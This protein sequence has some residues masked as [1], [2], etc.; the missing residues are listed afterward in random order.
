VTEFSAVVSDLLSHGEDVVLPRVI[1][2]K[3]STPREVGDSMAI[4]RNGEIAGTVGGG[5]IEATAVKKTP[6]MFQDKG[7]ARFQFDMT[8]DVLT[9][10]DM[11][12][13]RKVELLVEYLPADEEGSIFSQ[14][15]RVAGGIT[16]SA[17]SISSLPEVN[18]GKEPLKRFLLS[19]GGTC[20]TGSDGSAEVMERLKDMVHSLF[21][22]SLVE[23][24]EK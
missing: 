11:V 1:S 5:L 22:P 10:A 13:G 7:F 18:E 17:F 23:I 9:D 6:E 16:T 24:D 8:S 12:C 4:C 15:Y 2:V 21:G 19:P 3:G 14:A 20:A